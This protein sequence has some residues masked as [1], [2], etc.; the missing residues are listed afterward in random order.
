MFHFMNTMFWTDI[1]LLTDLSCSWEALPNGWAAAINAS[2]IKYNITIHA[3][4]K[5]NGSSCE[6]LDLPHYS[7]MLFAN[8]DPTSAANT[9]IYA[10][11]SGWLNPGRVVL[12][13][14]NMNAYDSQMLSQYLTQYYGEVGQ[15]VAVREG[16][17][18]T[19]KTNY[20]FNFFPYRTGSPTCGCILVLLVVLMMQEFVFNDLEMPGDS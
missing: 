5:T 2:S 7:V 14:T 13:N 20:K 16:K 9:L 17:R 18:E 4:L 6:S 12:F 10:Y 11:N 1:V 3:N 15:L 8:A 19:K